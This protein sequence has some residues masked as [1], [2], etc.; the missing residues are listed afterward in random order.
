MLTFPPKDSGYET[1]RVR[2]IE[3][4]P[5]KSTLVAVTGVQR[6]SLN[7]IHPYCLPNGCQQFYFVLFYIYYHSFALL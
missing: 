2:Y 5:S 6:L 1:V 3:I 4:L 7:P